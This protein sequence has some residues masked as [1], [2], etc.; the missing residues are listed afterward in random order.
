MA[1]LSTLTVAGIDGL[2]P[3]M[4]TGVCA[5]PA[6]LPDGETWRLLSGLPE[7]LQR[8]ILSMAVRGWWGDSDEARH[9]APG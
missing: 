3:L 5:P 2:G 6:A 4:A 7:D 9:R 1:S 8:I